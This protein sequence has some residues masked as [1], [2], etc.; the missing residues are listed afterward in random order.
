MLRKC[1]FRL[2]YDTHIKPHTKDEWNQTSSYY[3][4][5]NSY[6]AAQ[7]ETNLKVNIK[8]HFIQRVNSFVNKLLYSRVGGKE[9]KQKLKVVKKDLLSSTF[10]SD[11]E[12][13]EFITQHR[14]FIIP[15]NVH[16]N[17]IPYDLEADPVKYLYPTMYMNSVLEQGTDE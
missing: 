16:E 12:F 8:E 10:D 13:H 15:T 1:T 14:P 11:P 3:A 17:G 4:P 9:L 2:L 7:I 6:I 5:I